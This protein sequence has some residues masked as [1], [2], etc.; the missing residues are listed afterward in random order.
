[1]IISVGFV[2]NSDDMLCT[3][4]GEIVQFR[5]L[6]SSV[7]ALAIQVP[8]SRKGCCVSVVF[9]WG[10]L[11]SSWSLALDEHSGYKDL[12]DSDHRSVIPYV[13]GRTELY[14][15][16]LYEPEPFLFRPAFLSASVRRR[17]CELFIA[18]GRAVTLRPGA[19]QVAPRWLK[20]YTAFRV[21]MVR[22]SK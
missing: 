20:P 4:Q 11:L 9:L 6:M 21:I 16:R 7:K 5:T 17:L 2:L 13:H 22:S 3:C 18:Q 8:F 14:C 19:R 12:R 1:V 15:S 10:M